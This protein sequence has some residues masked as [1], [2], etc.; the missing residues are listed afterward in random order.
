MDIIV[1]RSGVCGAKAFFDDVTVPGRSEHWQQLWED[2]K[3]VIRVLVKAG[4]MLGLKKCQFLVPQVVVLG[5]QLIQGGY[6]LVTKFLRSWTEQ[7]PPRNLKGLQKILGKLLWASPFIPEF[8]RLVAPLEELL[9]SSSAG[10]WTPECTDAVN[11]MS[12]IM[13]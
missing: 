11:S 3:K 5:Y 7:H 4:F 13:H 9:S 10:E 2:T 6:K 8:K 12:R 1:S